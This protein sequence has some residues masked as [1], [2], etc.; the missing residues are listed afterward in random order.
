LFGLINNEN[1]RAGLVK[2][3]DLGQFRRDKWLANKLSDSITLLN[4][5]RSVGM[6]EQDDTERASII[7]IDDTGTDVDRMMKNETRPR[8][9]STVCTQR[10]SDPQVSANDLLVSRLNRDVHCR[11]KIKSGSKW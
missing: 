2:M 7:V 1:G 5:K 10:H 11:I 8:S 9:D 3:V 4:P 6:I